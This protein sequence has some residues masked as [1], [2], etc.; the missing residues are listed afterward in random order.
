M[1]ILRWVGRKITWWNVFGVCIIGVLGISLFSLSY[2]GSEN[3]F[4]GWSS[5][6]KD[7]KLSSLRTPTWIIV[8]MAWWVV[9]FVWFMLLG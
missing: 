4:C 6:L 3:K 9:R 2:P 1:S 7:S 5:N 8:V